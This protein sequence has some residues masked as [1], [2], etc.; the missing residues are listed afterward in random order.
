MPGTQ[1]SKALLD[2]KVENPGFTDADPLDWSNVSSYHR[3][4]TFATKYVKITRSSDLEFE[5]V[6]STPEQ[7]EVIELKYVTVRKSGLLVCV[8]LAAFCVLGVI[9]VWTSLP[10]S[11]TEEAPSAFSEPTTTTTRPAT[12]TVPDTTSTTV[13]S[14]AIPVVVIQPD[15]SAQQPTTTVTTAPSTTTTSTTATTAPPCSDPVPMAPPQTTGSQCN[16]RQLEVFGT[17]AEGFQISA[18]GGWTPGVNYQVFLWDPSGNPVVQ[19]DQGAHPIWADG[20]IP[21]DTPDG[22]T[23][24]CATHGVAGPGPYTILI[25]QLDNPPGADGYN[26]NPWGATNFYVDS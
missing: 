12:T 1:V 2:A 3:K 22:W 26:D 6:P 5:E 9:A 7:K 25:V 11:S 14:Q 23:F 17:C 4:F 20:S 18:G 13:R 19:G 21:S 10:D 24:D 16:P 15:H 8:V